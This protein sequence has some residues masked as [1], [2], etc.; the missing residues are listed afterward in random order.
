MKW[1]TWKPDRPCWWDCSDRHTRQAF[2]DYQNQRREAL[3]KDFSRAK[4]DSMELS[5][6][7]SPAD[8]L[9]AFFRSRER[10]SADGHSFCADS[11][12]RIRGSGHAPGD[13]AC[14]PTGSAPD[15]ACPG[16]RCKA[17]RAI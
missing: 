4:V 16:M 6:D 15:P 12:A 11:A 2:T 14:C 17:D 10:G 7:G 8:V 1:K 9:H 13:S 5:T 3:R